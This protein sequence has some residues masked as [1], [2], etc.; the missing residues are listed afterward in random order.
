MCG[1]VCVCVCVWLCS[2]WMLEC[3]CDVY[4]RTCVRALCVCGECVVSEWKPPANVCAPH[5]YVDVC[6]LL[7]LPAHVDYCTIVLE[8]T[9]VKRQK[10][11]HS[12]STN[13]LGVKRKQHGWFSVSVPVYVC[14]DVIIVLSY[15]WL[16]VCV[17][18]CVY[19]C[20]S[21]YGCEKECI[22]LRACVVWCAVCVAG[23]YL[24]T[25]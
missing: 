17:C 4:V 21:L 22:F 7:R 15:S 18:V 14:I 9:Q 19:A 20:V 16:G 10:S 6:R 1:C 12:S 2:A 5:T 13:E 25:A 24:Y 3:L 11:D 23:V 8:R